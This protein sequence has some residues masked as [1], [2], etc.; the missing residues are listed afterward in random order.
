MTRC[1]CRL[2]FDSAGC[3]GQLLCDY[4]REG[5]SVVAWTRQ[6]E[7]CSIVCLCC[8]PTLQS[9]LRLCYSVDCAIEDCSGASDSAASSSPFQSRDP[10]Y[11]AMCVLCRCVAALHWMHW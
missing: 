6:I 7:H 8:L 5:L 10:C 4:G 11:I 1:E 9:C 2:S 3:K